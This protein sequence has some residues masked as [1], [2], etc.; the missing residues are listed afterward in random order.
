LDERP[1]VSVVPRPLK[2]IFCPGK[3]FDINRIRR[4]IS[5]DKAARH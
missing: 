4:T 1:Y 3:F 2:G 5:G